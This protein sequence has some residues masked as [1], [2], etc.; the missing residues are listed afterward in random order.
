MEQNLVALMAN[1]VAPTDSEIQQI[2]TLLKDGAEELV[3]LQ[4]SL[5]RAITALAN[6]MMQRRRRSKE[7][8]SL[9]AV[10]SPIRRVPPEI[11][12]EI[13]QLCVQTTMA[14]SSAFPDS[15]PLG[16]VCSS[17]RAISH[18]TP[19]LWNRIVFAP[20]S[21]NQYTYLLELAG[22][23]LQRPL[24]I[25]LDTEE[26]ALPSGCTRP[27][28]TPL[29][30]LS[31][32]TINLIL[33]LDHRVLHLPASD[34][35]FPMLTS[36]TISVTSESSNAVAPV[37]SL[38]ELL[39]IFHHAPALH[40]L[41][42]IA[43]FV[44]PRFHVPSQFGWNRL[45]KLELMVHL[46]VAQAGD[47]LSHCAQLEKCRIFHL[48]S[49]DTDDS[50]PQPMPLS[51]LPNLRSLGIRVHVDDGPVSYLFRRFAF[52]SLTHLDVDA[53]TFS[54]LDLVDLHAR[55]MFPLQSLHLAAYVTPPEIIPFLCSLPT[56]ENVCFKRTIVQNF[57]FKAFTAGTFPPN[58]SSSSQNA[59]PRTA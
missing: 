5:H 25:T 16:Q 46:S 22:K 26:M 13:F 24:S 57:L 27:S 9:T 56:L 35:T 19:R 20:H 1:N 28:L 42:L 54:L 11:L 49:R 6:L 17:W 34:C 32:R 30:A 48:R 44:S 23:S 58:P 3:E 55:S 14:S 18:N 7:I 38:V 31:S 39:D 2:R 12:A 8:A 51:V 15:L 45:R 33:H 52:P 36:L 21:Q 50:L 43:D 29:W 10:L 53:F 4:K 41:G 47:I 40:H 59:A 37:P